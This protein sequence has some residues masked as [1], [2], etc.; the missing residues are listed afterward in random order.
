MAIAFVGLLFSDEP[1]LNQLSFFL[2]FAVLFDTLVVR[3]ILVPALMA[4]LGK[5][6]WWPGSQSPQEGA[7]SLQDSQME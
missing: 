3:S 1:I 7:F 2:V 4:L 5:W 6:N